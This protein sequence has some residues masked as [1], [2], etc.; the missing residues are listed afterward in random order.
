VAGRNHNRE[1]D[2]VYAIESL[3]PDS[4][5]GRVVVVALGAAFLLLSLGLVQ[6]IYPPPFFRGFLVAVGIIFSFDVVVF[7]WVFQLHRI[8]DGSEA[9][10]IEPVLVAI[11][12]GFVLHG[13]LRE[14]SQS[15]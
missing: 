10:V 11:G 12:L 8:T 13:L 3:Q 4:V 7:H 9:D 14:R 2:L 1:K 6:R 15:T 5:A